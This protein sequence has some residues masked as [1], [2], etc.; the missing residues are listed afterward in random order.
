M[1]LHLFLSFFGAEKRL[2]ESLDFFYAVIFTKPV[3]FGLIGL[4]SKC[5][6]LVQLS[7][8]LL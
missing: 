8:R 4:L 2:E 7:N 6:M 5:L 1:I 3:S